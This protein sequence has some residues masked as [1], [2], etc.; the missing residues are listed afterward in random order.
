MKLSWGRKVALY[1][2]MVLLVCILLVAAS[3]EST[4]TAL[5]AD[6][7]KG[8]FE[9]RLGEEKTIGDATVVYLGH[10]KSLDLVYFSDGNRTFYY[11]VKETPTRIA[12]GGKIYT[13]MG[14]DNI[15]AVLRMW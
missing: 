3:Q 13:L 6:P 11:T 10:A 4:A 7:M 15:R 12:I 1:G 5:T 14:Y 2:T 8:E 9:V